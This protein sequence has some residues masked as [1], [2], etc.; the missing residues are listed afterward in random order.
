M[1]QNF[2]TEEYICPVKEHPRDA[3]LRFRAAQECRGSKPTDSVS[4]LELI[5]HA[6]FAHTRQRRDVLQGSVP[7]HLVI[8]TTNQYRL[9]QIALFLTKARKM[10]Q[11]TDLF[12]LVEV[13]SCTVE[14]INNDNCNNENTVVTRHFFNPRF[15]SFLIFKNKPLGLTRV[16]G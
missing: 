6:G 12:L 16:S 4:T 11:V 3:L 9:Q 14:S 7:Y 10:R 8:K 1:K 5:P 13:H 15:L 2:G